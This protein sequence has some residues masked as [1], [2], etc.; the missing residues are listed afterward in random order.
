MR[1]DTS[2]FRWTVGIEDTFIPQVRRNGRALDE[3]ELTQHYDNWRAD[4]DL[5]AEAGADT[6]RYGIP[7]YRVNPEPGRFDWSWTD[8]VLEH[9]AGTLGITPI[10]DLMHYGC[11]LWLDGQFINPDYPDR[12][13]EY[14]HAFV[15]RYRG[16]LSWYTPL[17]EP[18]VNARACGR[19]GTWPPYLRGDRGYLRVMMAL[20]RG[21][22]LTVAAIRAAQP[23]ATIVQVEAA[24]AI[25]T[26][27]P[28]LA[29]ERA[30]Q[31]EQ[32]YLATDLLLGRVDDRH[33]LHPWMAAHGV[34]EHDLDWIHDHAQRVDVAGVNFYPEFSRK[35]LVADGDTVRRIR[36]GGWTA[37]L[38]GLLR[39]W[40][41]RYGIPTMVTETSTAKSV[42]GR[43]RW[44]DDSAAAVLDTRREGV[45]VIGY[46]WWPLFSL[47]TWAYRRGRKPL[48]Q[49]IVHMG[50]WDL[51]E[52]ASRLERVRTPVA[53]RFIELTSQFDE[54]ERT[55]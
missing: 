30:L 4:L 5:A 53:D 35:N 7:W 54:L 40:H 49:Y 46:T 29:V 22:S 51:R 21:M 47:I 26:D 11:P 34:R 28:S 42:R 6:M 10:V 32:Q 14:A 18:R 24:E 36:G 43:L 9:L 23:D 41:E 27:D 50:L 33:P 8:A 45:Q 44:L 15:E 38:R 19:N 37:D 17:N 1:P 48:G 3:Y 20:A 16:L 12:V 13:A 2:T 39:D 31:A 25:V 55:A 52:A